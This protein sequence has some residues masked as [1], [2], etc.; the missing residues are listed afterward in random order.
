[1]YLSTHD[2]A[3]SRERALNDMQE[4]V[5]ACVQA[6][7]QL[8]M[9]VASAGRDGLRLGAHSMY[10]GR[11]EQALDMAQWP[12]AWWLDSA[13][14][15]GSL[16]DEAW[17]VFGDT[18]KALIRSVQQQV[19]IVDDL[20]I[21]AI[22]RAYKA[23]PEGLEPALTALHDSLQTLERALHVLSEAA[24]GLIERKGLPACC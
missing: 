24:I 14:R 22:S 23:C 1:M 20:A 19:R 2:V 9:A 7:H 10:L 21:V 8:T 15:A 16:V 5:V 18:Q 13:A 11:P 6:G 17:R 3:Q 12:V 4:F